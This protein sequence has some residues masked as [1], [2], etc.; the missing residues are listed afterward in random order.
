[1]TEKTRKTPTW[2]VPADEQDEPRQ[3]RG[4]APLREDGPAADRRAAQPDASRESGRQ[5]AATSERPRTLSDQDTTQLSTTPA[6][7]SDAKKPSTF[8]KKVLSKPSTFAAG[9]AGESKT[10]AAGGSFGKAI[11]DGLNRALPTP[12]SRLFALMGAL[13]I[14][15]IVIV[16][17]G[18]GVGSS[19]APPESPAASPPANASAKASL[20][21]PQ[22]PA[23]SKVV[24]T[25]VTFGGLNTT[26]DGKA[27]LS[28][29]GLNWDGSVSKGKS[30]ETITLKGPTAVQIRQGF[31]MPRSSI[32]SGVF[33][34]AQQGGDI[35]HVVFNTFEAGDTEITQGSIFAV[36]DDKLVFS[37]YYR[38]QRKTAS[39]TVI[40]TYMPPGGQN[41]R[42]SF[43]APEGTPIPLLVGFK[44]VDSSGGGS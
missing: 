19:D 8:V 30:G 20:A 29:A 2:L 38:D 1:M 36:K 33:A 12:R 5:P 26:K 7:T 10:A 17:Y 4:A 35:L 40:R 24:D 39:D 28:G 41:Y 31:E 23:D 22:A 27:S 25:S 32:Q 44:G 34:V 11:G 37:G 16:L 14:V 18:L 3:K 9:G 6:D 43:K 13:L 21:S 15:G 42:R